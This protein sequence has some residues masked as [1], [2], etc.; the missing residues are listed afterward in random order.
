MQIQTPTIAQ[1]RELPSLLTLTVPKDWEDLNGHV[2]VQ[3]YLGVYNQT[4]PALFEL[5]GIDENRFVVE[6]IGFFEL[7][8]HTWFLNEIMAGDLITAYMRFIAKS[9]KRFH[10]V[11]FI[12]NNTRGVVASALEFLTTGADLRTRRTSAL[13]DDVA[14]RIGDLIT[15]HN[16]LAWPAPQSGAI[17]P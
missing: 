7:E 4:G 10:G 6:R 16:R 3:H 17:K 2:N 11:M 5:M 1:V 8:H 12:A 15:A 9:A 14:A 13:T